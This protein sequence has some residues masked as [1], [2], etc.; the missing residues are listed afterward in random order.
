MQSVQAWCRMCLLL[1]SQLEL[2]Q[3]ELERSTIWICPPCPCV[4]EFAWLLGWEGK[5]GTE[6]KFADGTG[7]EGWGQR[8]SKRSSRTWK[9]YL[10]WWQINKSLHGQIRLR[11]M[12]W[13]DTTANLGIYSVCQIT[14][15]CFH[16][17]NHTIVGVDICFNVQHVLGSVHEQ[18]W[19]NIAS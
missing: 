13:S 12:S 4:G 3:I 14:S 16:E 18:C 11:A 5:D 19:L 6:K 1:L 7:R 17:F 15:I 2:D 9:Y 8:Y 10:H